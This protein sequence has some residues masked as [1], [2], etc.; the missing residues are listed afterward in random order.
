M[1]ERRESLHSGDV[2]WQDLRHFAAFVRART[3]SAAAAQLGVDHATVGRRILALEA[4]LGLKLVDRRARIPVLTAAGE[5]IAALVG[6]V[7]AAADAVGRAARG[8]KP[9]LAGEVSVSAPPTLAR[10]LIAPRLGALRARHAALR[11]LLVGDKRIVSLARREADV[12]LRLV[13]P[14][15]AGVVGRRI[16]AFEF[17]LYAAADYLANRPRSRIELIGFD[18]DSEALP[19]QRWLRAQARRSRW[20]I[21]LRTNDLESQLAAARAGAGAAALPSFLAARHPELAP[22]AVR[23]RRG[24]DG[25]RL[26]REVWLVVHG[27]LRAAPSVRAVMDFLVEA[28]AELRGATSASP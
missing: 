10:T 3:L 12:A 8:L 16:G 24:R 27:D 21:V 5:R 25:A 19:Q 7:E 20:P 28:T 9:E 23:A 18:D 2:D 22:V 17:G 1:H 13:R 15:E 4:S 14:V 11:I 26:V 6:G